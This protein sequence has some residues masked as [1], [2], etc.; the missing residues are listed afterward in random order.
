MDTPNDT[1]EQLKTLA[2]M[3]DEKGYIV[4]S[5]VI[6]DT[7]DQAFLDNG[8]N[9]SVGGL[10]LM[11]DLKA[12]APGVAQTMN[13]PEEDMPLYINIDGVESVVAAWRL[14]TI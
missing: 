13:A 5:D 2:D 6:Y 7:I 9:Y 1:K 3:L 4:A 11:E 10:A 14:K 8:L 12:L